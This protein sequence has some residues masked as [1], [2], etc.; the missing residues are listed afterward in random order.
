[1]FTMWL[2]PRPF[3][4]G[5]MY[6][7]CGDS[8]SEPRNHQM[9]H[10]DREMEQK[11][12]LLNKY[13]PATPF[14]RIHHTALATAVSVQVQM[15]DILSAPSCDL[16][17]RVASISF[18]TTPLPRCV[19]SRLVPSRCVPSHPSVSSRKILGVSW[20]ITVF[21]SQ[22]CSN[23]LR[24]FIPHGAEFEQNNCLGLFL[25]NDFKGNPTKLI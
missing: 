5:N 23:A 16:H 9:L 8:E 19:V 14:P 3:S 11:L 7:S 13:L 2:T 1:M 15:K 18:C 21:P 4:A 22:I 25:E 20:D 17:R 10:T 12:Y 6:S 24:A